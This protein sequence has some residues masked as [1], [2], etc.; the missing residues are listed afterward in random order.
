MPRPW[1]DRVFCDTSFFFA[2]LEPRDVH[3]EDAMEWLRL[4]RRHRTV[5][6]STW[7]VLSESVTLL[8]RKPGYPRAMR[9]VE[10]V[11]PALRLA[12]VDDSLRL[13]ALE[14]FKRFAG[15]KKLS[16]CDC[17]SYVVLTTVL[18]NIPTATFDAHFAAM[19]LPILD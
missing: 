3:H 6:W 4:S 12:A 5:F 7:D 9:F 19:G 11:I 17:L 16:F 13:E 14:V 2:C 8:R 15:D 10:R 18:E 1:P